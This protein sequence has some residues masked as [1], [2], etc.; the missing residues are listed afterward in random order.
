MIP[1]PETALEEICR[2]FGLERESLTFLGGGRED[3]DGIVYAIPRG[4]VL[5]ILPLSERDGEAELALRERMAFARHLAGQGVPIVAPLAEAGDDPLR[6]GGSAEG[7]FAGYRMKRLPGTPPPPDAFTPQLVTAWGGALGRLHRATQSWPHW[8]GSAARDA[9]GKPLISWERERDGFLGMCRDE[10]VTRAWQDVC[11]RIA[12][13]PVERNGFGFTH[14]DPH[15][16]NILF[17][18]EGIH[19]LDFD[20]ANAIWFASDIAIT[21]QGLSFGP[22]GGMERPVE[23]QDLLQDFLDTFMQG[24]WRENPSLAPSW[25]EQINLFVAY[26][27]ILIFIIVQ[28]FLA[29]RPEVRQ[30]WLG[31]IREEPPLLRF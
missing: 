31:M 4:E 13:L 25:L 21:L 6:F 1:V 19:F 10:E 15:N 20:V 27:R 3:S 11:A 14:N 23:R 26:R 9:A 8:Q 18:G 22:A 2:A 7:R 16:Q 12:K 30:S 29:E 28:E 24:Y 17:D 5:K